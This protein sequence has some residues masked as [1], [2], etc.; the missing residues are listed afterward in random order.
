[1][2]VTRNQADRTKFNSDLGLPYELRI[3]DFQA[4][5]NDVYDFSSLLVFH[6][7]TNNV[8]LAR[9]QCFNVSASIDGH[10]H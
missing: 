7:A 10:N 8:G 5:I 2:P 3:S 9:S 6:D 1:M 4:A